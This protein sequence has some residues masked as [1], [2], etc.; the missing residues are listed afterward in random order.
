MPLSK[1]KVREYADLVNLEKK[2][3]GDLFTR[4]LN[5]NAITDTE[6][7]TLLEAGAEYYGK[8]GVNYLYYFY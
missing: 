7:T 4:G 8:E 5:G 1:L 3:H 2:N 6:K